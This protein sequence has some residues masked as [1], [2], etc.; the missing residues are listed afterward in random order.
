MM[1]VLVW[2]QMALQ[3]KPPLETTVLGY[4]E[5]LVNERNLGILQGLVTQN[6]IQAKEMM[7]HLKMISLTLKILDLRI[8]TT[9]PLF[10]L[11]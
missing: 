2:I 5:P 1:E 6:L 11:G 3:Q 4:A 7:V 8:L 9:E 10:E